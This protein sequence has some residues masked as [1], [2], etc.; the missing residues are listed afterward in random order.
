[1]RGS[2]F[3]LSDVKQQTLLL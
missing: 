3:Q 1:M 2:F